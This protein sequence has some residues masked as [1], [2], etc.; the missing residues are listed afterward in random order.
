MGQRENL[1]VGKGFWVNARRLLAGILWSYKGIQ[2]LLYA[3]MRLLREEGQIDSKL[4]EK[5]GRKA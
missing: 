4:S 2:G 3:N 1:E 5:M